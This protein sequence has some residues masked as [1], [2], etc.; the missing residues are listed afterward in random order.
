MLV[1]GGARR[2]PADTQ[3]HRHTHLLHLPLISLVG[4]GHIVGEGVWA[5]E[6][7]VAAG[8]GD[9]VALAGDLASKAGDG[10]GDLVDLAEKE[11]GREAAGD[12]GRWGGVSHLWCFIFG[13]VA[14][15]TNSWG[16]SH[17]SGY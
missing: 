15:L 17:A 13:G 6:V 5:G 2:Q 11:D 10:A 16:G 12:W 4:A 1:A 8:S 7:V 14:D 3:T 9:D